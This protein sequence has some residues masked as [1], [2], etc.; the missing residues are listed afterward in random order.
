MS[1]W[2]TPYLVPKEDD[3]NAE[4]RRKRSV[5]QKGLFG[6]SWQFNFAP[7]LFSFTQKDNAGNE[8]IERIVAYSVPSEIDGQTVKFFICKLEQTVLTIKG[9]QA[10]VN[11]VQHPRDDKLFIV[12]LMQ[13]DKLIQGTIQLP[14]GTHYS[15]KED[16]VR[17]DYEYYEYLAYDE[18]KTTGD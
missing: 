11:L 1:S 12:T 15:H 16:F 7:K 13:K 10:V 5:F 2:C 6:I 9:V 4:M 18:I 14:V 3:L 8:S 17:D